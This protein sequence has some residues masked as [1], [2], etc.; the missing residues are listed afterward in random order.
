MC[1]Q[2]GEAFQA[3]PRII[4][5]SP[6]RKS[7]SPLT[8]IDIAP[9]AAVRRPSQ[10]FADGLARDFA[11]WVLR[12]LENIRRSGHCLFAQN[13]FDEAMRCRSPHVVGATIVLGKVLSVWADAPPRAVG[14]FL[15]LGV[16]YPEAIG[17]NVLDNALQTVHRVRQ[18]IGRID[19]GDRNFGI[20][21]GTYP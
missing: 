11:I 1:T 18:I 12:G 17:E 3:P 4:S 7:V 10:G 13:A 16:S 19:D 6:C 14:V 9:I 2:G 5:V 21:H 20:C 15:G 8:V